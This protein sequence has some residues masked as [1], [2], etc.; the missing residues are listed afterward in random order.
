MKP[1]RHWS[2]SPAAGWPTPP[3]DAFYGLAGDIVRTV[4]PHSE[5]DPVAVLVQVLVAFGNAIGRGAHFVAG[6]GR[7]F[8]NEFAGL[9][10][11]NAKARKGSSWAQVKALFDV[12]EPHWA[13]NRVL[14]GLSS[15]EGLIWQVRDAVIEHAAIREQ[16]KPPRIEKVEKDAGVSD[17]RLLVFEPEFGGTLR[18]T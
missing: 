1:E 18:V 3:T 4:E 14:S 8:P 5:A 17:K 13:A 12:L 15:G 2:P 16:G 10:G 7:H 9:V 11:E 6:R